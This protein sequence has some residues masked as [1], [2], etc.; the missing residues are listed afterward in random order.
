MATTTPTIECVL[1]DLSEADGRDSTPEPDVLPNF[2][3]SGEDRTEVDLAVDS[4]PLEPP[5]AVD[6]LPVLTSR[7]LGGRH[8]FPAGTQDPTLMK[9]YFSEWA[10]ELR[11]T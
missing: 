10:G 11:A 2:V 3:T 1:S 4:P 7:D 8:R 9:R 5:E 6:G